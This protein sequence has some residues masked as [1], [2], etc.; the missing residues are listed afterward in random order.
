MT[1]YWPKTCKEIFDRHWRGQIQC[2]LRNPNDHPVALLSMLACMDLALN[3][4]VGNPLDRRPRKSKQE[5]EINADSLLE[6]YF[7]T[8]GFPGSEKLAD[9]LVNGLKHVAFIR[10]EIVLQDAKDGVLICKPIQVIG[11]KI[12]VAPTAF[13]QRVEAE[14]D[15]IYANKN[16]CFPQKL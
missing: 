8:S 10:P 5:K 6:Y 14:I 15:K 11:E 4:K 16:C 12:H 3:C 9:S 1:S 7:P 2:L 13:W